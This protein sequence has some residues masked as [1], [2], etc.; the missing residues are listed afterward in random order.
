MVY[1]DNM[2]IK[3]RRMIMCHMIADTTEEL[4]DMATKIGMN[5][6]WIQDKETWQEHFDIC[7]SMKTKALAIGAKDI[8][9]R[10]LA[11]LLRKRPGSPYYKE[12]ENI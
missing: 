6:K 10:E 5:H 12:D 3:Y 7:L 8:P 1:I 11:M 4:L 9:M 2:N